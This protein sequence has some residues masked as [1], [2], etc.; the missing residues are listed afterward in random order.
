[1]KV[2]GYT[3]VSHARQLREDQLSLKSQKSQIKAYAELKGWELELPPFEERAISGAIGLEK[4]P[5]GKRLLEE[6]GPGDVVIVAKL[7]RM[8]RNILDALNTLEDLKKRGV[9][10]HIIDLGGDVTGNGISKLMF[11]ILGAFAEAERD[12][13]GERIKDAKASMRQQGKFQGG[14]VDFGYR[15]DDDGYLVEVPAQQ[16]ALKDM[17]TL[18]KEG[19]SYRTISERINRKYYNDGV[20]ISHEGVRRLLMSDEDPRQKAKAA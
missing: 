2:Y 1:M 19:M 5:K 17:F 3:R 14:K 8:F 10:L 6:L 7:D 16:A 18:R 20:K 4:R 9:S 15:V 12:R 13:I 11:T